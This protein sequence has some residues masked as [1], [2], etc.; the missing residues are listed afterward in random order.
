MLSKEFSKPVLLDS[1]LRY[2]YSTGK[3]ASLLSQRSGFPRLIGADDLM[4]E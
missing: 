2:Q 4:R 1:A 3:R